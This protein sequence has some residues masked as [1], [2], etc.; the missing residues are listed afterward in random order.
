MSFLLFTAA[1]IGFIHSLAPGHWLPVALM[2]RSRKWSRRLAL[3]GALVTASGHILISLTLAAAGIWIGAHFVHGREEDLERYGAL[4]LVVFGLAYAVISLFRHSRCH[5]H[6]HHGPAP[7]ANKGP[8]LF[9]FGLGL[10]PCVAAFPI[11]VAAAA[12][13]RL[14]VISSMLAFAFGVILASTV[15]S[16]LALRGLSYLDHP[17][18]EHHGDV[19]TGAGIVTMGVVLYFFPI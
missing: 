17:I 13:S 19:L 11:F 7:S 14:A 4:L 15:A 8:F 18:L 10:S 16:Q 2:A 5:G 1:G 3:G 6:S 12:I 9:L